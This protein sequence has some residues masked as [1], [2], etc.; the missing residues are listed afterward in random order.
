MAGEPA[1]SQPPDT[2]GSA[3][4]LI[5][6]LAPLFL[7]SGKTTTTSSSSPAATSNNQAIFNQALGNS[8]DTSATDA[9]VQN[10]MNKAAIAFAPVVGQQNTAG[11]YN[12]STLQLLAGQASGEATAQ[13]AQAVL[14]Y[15][16]SQEQIAAQ[17]ANSIANSNRTT[18]SQTAPVVDPTLSILGAA[19]SLGLSAA[20]TFF[21]NQV[22]G[23][24]DSITSGAKKLFSS[25]GD[26]FKSGTSNADIANGAYDTG[27]AL[28]APPDL[29]GAVSGSFGQVSDA[30]TA[31]GSA[32]DIINNGGG[33]F[34]DAAS[35]AGDTAAIDT[36]GFLAGDA[37]VATAQ[38]IADFGGTAADFGANAGADIGSEVGTA[39]GAETTGLTASAALDIA[40]PYAALGGAVHLAGT[41]VGGDEGTALQA[42]GDLG[43][44]SNGIA[45]V[46]AAIGDGIGGDVG[47]AITDVTDPIGAI[48]DAASVICTALSSQ[49]KLNKQLY[50]IGSRHFQGYSNEARTAYYA[51][52]RKAANYIKCNPN[53]FGSNIFSFVFYHRAK[54][55]ANSLG[56]RQY[57]STML[58]AL[59]YHS[60]T[61]ICVSIHIY[62]TRT[63]PHFLSDFKI[64]GAH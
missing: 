23:V 17:A 7:G 36:T 63:F 33:S 35:L 48:A 28:G 8:N 2:L 58:D 60:I 51:F 38:D 31:A 44:P 12:T 11:L 14:N 26:L 59:C 54:Y 34:L 39:A 40:E 20:K 45:D 42:I 13:S 30:G 62:K 55:L 4:H 29:G 64:V 22:K 25:A 53:S 32:A 27:G 56:Y 37:G 3:A 46:G 5:S 52:A 16:T 50:T 6:T 21:P 1:I 24:G 15:K 57:R 61:L 9:I 19:G 47:T 43:S 49:G 41:L 10:I 18:T